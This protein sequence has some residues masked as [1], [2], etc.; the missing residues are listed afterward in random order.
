MSEEARGL[1]GV[2][3]DALADAVLARAQQLGV[4]SAE[5]RVESLRHQYV[6]LRDARLETA[7]DNAEIGVGLRVVYD[8]SMGFAA[9]VDLSTDA[10]VDL[11]DVAIGAARRVGALASG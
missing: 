7:V 2:P 1:E 5:V 6:G 10:C 11:V 8:G 4:T 3:T 9:T